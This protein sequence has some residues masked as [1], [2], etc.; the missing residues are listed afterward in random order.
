MGIGSGI[1]WFTFLAFQTNQTWMLIVGLG[2]VTFVAGPLW[3][4]WIARPFWRRARKDDA[5]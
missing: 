4:L 3:H 2:S 1:A 5:P